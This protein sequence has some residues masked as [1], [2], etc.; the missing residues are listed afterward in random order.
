MI[1]SPPD[2]AAAAYNAWEGV[3]LMAEEDGDLAY[4][5]AREY[6]RACREISWNDDGYMAWAERRYRENEVVYLVWQ[7]ETKPYGID[8]HV[9][10]D[11]SPTI[12]Q[13]HRG[14]IHCESRENATMLGT[15]LRARS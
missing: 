3:T 12:G 6:A 11:Q 5:L 7:D 4:W 1:T 13:I 9:L 10:K 14:V 8:C 2:P 15:M